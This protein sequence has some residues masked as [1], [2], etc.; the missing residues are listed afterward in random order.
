MYILPDQK[1]AVA[2]VLV[3]RGGTM[4]TGVQVGR[5]QQRYLEE[6]QSKQNGLASPVEPDRVVPKAQAVSPGTAQS[7]AERIGASPIEKP[8]ESTPGEATL[9]VSPTGALRG[10]GVPSPAI[11]NGVPQPVPYIKTISNKPASASD[12]FIY[13]GKDGGAFMEALK[14]T[15]FF[16]VG[17]G[18]RPAVW[19]L[20]DPQCPFCHMAW[21]KLKPLVF[22]GKIQVRVIM[23]AGLKGSDPLARSILGRA[24]PSKAWLSGEGSID[25][26]P[27]KEGPAI[28]SADYDRAG[29]YVRINNG[30][31]TRYMIKSTPFLAYNTPDGK[32][33]TSVGLP[34]DMDAF[35]AALR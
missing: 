14:Q 17:L 20:A 25:K 21:A 35:L 18:D 32:L 13:P 19:M 28:G 16:T 9:P 29:Q 24:E 3:K 33:F 8:A 27:V 30:F 26:V 34:Q 10:E 1:H 15:V 2:G 22:D 7:L 6:E 31:A 5:L 12:A 11:P 4:M 23:I